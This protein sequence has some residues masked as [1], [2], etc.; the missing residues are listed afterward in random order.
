MKKILSV[1]FVASLLVTGCVSPDSILAAADAGL[2]AYV[3]SVPDGSDQYNLAEKID[4]ELLVFSVLY[5]DAETASSSSK[6]DIASKIAALAQT[7]AADDKEFLT[8]VGV[9]NPTKQA[10][11]GGV[12][13]AVEA[14]IVVV[15]NKY[16]DPSGNSVQL[17]ST[18]AQLKAATK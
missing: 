15:Q 9:K 3:N 1:L 13:A 7:L 6:P 10:V 14:F 12:I 8:L 18:A 16:P 2:K 4:N 5:H 17:N 11:V